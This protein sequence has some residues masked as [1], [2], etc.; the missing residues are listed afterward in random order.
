MEGSKTVHY[1]NRLT[2]YEGDT[3]FL[4][5]VTPTM[6][7]ESKLEEELGDN[8]SL[9]DRFLVED[10]YMDAVNVSKLHWRSFWRAWLMSVRART[11]RFWSKVDWFYPNIIIYYIRNMDKLNVKKE[12]NVPMNKMNSAHLFFVFTPLQLGG[13][14]YLRN[15]QIHKNTWWL[16]VSVTEEGRFI[17]VFEIEKEINEKR[18]TKRKKNLK[19]LM[20]IKRIFQKVHRDCK[21]SLVLNSHN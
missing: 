14:V 12:P 10:G 18:Y 17:F 4:S 8:Q 19:K 9:T 3:D 13:S 7:E 5:L 16:R 1:D 6:E 20:K 15:L 21:V 11:D 2:V